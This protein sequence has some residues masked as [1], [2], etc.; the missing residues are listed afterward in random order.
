M[1][2]VILA[3][4][5]GTRL[6][7]ETLIKPKPLVDIGNKPIIWHIMKIYS[8]YGIND[9]IICLGYKGYLIKEYF[10]NYFLHNSDLTIDLKKNST[11][12]HQ[13]NSEN[14][15]VTLVDTG[16]DTLTGGRILK[17]KKYIKSDFLLT[18]GDGLSNVNIKKLI[19]FHKNNR[20]LVTVTAIQP[21]G[22]FG[23]I[24]I[25]KKNKVTNFKEKPKG[26]NNWING[27]FFVLK[28]GIFDFLEND[29]SVWEQKPL[30]EMTKRNQVV[31]FKHSGF[32]HAMDTVRDKLLLDNLWDQN[33]APWK[34][35]NE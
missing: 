26:D 22:R 14:W 24:D 33:R 10:A 11:T 18:Y 31:A 4:G 1:K 28:P 6:T 35:W 27:G 8:H 20:K 25:N 19:H 5:R 3:G 32:W 16:D 17:I 34:I 13:K 12:I 23:I 30:T 15:K 9:F 7:E 2:L 21:Q 29:S